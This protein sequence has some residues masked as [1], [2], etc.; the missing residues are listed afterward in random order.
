[1]TLH[2]LRQTFVWGNTTTIKIKTNLQ[3]HRYI[4]QKKVYKQDITQCPITQDHASLLYRDA[5]RDTKTNPGL[6]RDINGAK[7]WCC[8]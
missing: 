3:Q 4:Y 6:L 1:M 7:L 8:G 5:Y 2:R